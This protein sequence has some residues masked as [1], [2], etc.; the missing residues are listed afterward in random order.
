[1]SCSSTM[2]TINL[3]HELSM[4]LNFKKFTYILSI[5]FH[6]P[7]FKNLHPVDLILVYLL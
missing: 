1:M 3:A 2:S 5:L 7:I 6:L 4:D